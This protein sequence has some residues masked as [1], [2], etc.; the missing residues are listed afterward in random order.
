M[1]SIVVPG[2]RRA[3]AAGLLTLTVVTA[4][5]AGAAVAADS[6]QKS[7]S[8]WTVQPSS[9]QGPGTRAHF[10]YDLAP[11]GTVSDYVGV[12]NLSTRPLTLR[13][14]AGDAFN[15]A[16]GGFDLQPGSTQP[17]DVGS[18]VSLKQRRITIPARR[19]LDIPFTLTVPAGATPGDHAGGIVASLVTRTSAADGSQVSVD[20][21][22]GTRIYLRVD[23]PLR[24]AGTVTQLETGY[25]GTANPIGSGTVNLAYSVRNTG[26]TRLSGRIA[27]VVKAPFGFELSRQDLGALPELLPGNTFNGTAELTEV[28]PAVRLGTEL[29]VSPAGLA[30]AQT[31]QTSTG[32][33]PAVGTP[34]PPVVRASST[35]AVPWNLLSI[36]VALL[37][38][39]F[40]FFRRRRAPA[41]ASTQA[42]T[43]SPAPAPETASTTP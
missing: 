41:A 2:I 14:Y 17:T 42:P 34:L 31:A 20:N 29:E 15:T 28:R 36:V 11:G 35:W 16:T 1:S 40:A 10:G 27:A 21:R 30:G 23:G 13:L 37:V 22:V 33:V 24:P 18:W 25:S 7:P 6:P 38:L 3:V 43:Q 39:A 19:R 9:A 32:A 8:T 26:N 4:L 5:P 12:T